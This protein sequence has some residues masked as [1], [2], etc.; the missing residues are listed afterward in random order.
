MDMCLPKFGIYQVTVVFV[1]HL[2]AFSLTFF[3]YASEL[4]LQSN[5]NFK[6]I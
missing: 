6:N 3:A 4:N 5:I 2:V 1:E